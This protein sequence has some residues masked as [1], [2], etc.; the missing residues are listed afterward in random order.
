MGIPNISASG[1]SGKLLEFVRVYETNDV[2]FCA[3]VDQ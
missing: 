2:Y 1:F 3:F